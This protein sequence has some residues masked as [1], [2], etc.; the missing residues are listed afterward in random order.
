MAINATATQDYILD[1][2]T[3]SHTQGDIAENLVALFRKHGPDLEEDIKYG[4]IV[5]LKEGKIIGG[6]FSYK[7]HLSVE[8]SRGAQ[9]DDPNS[10][11][12]GKGKHRRHL[13]FRDLD[14]IQSQ[15]TET[16]IQQANTSG[17]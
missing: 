14:D 5:F 2:K 3:N 7:D 13:K 12:E 6:I 9:F 4:G 16:F 17:H 11:L 10:R 8:F 15:D 1:L